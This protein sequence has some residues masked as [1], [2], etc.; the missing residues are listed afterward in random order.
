MEEGAAES[1][2]RG[3]GI[4]RREREPAKALVAFCILISVVG[5]CVYKCV[6]ILGSCALRSFVSYVKKQK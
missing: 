2:G 6:K 4:R 1:Q 3:Q 5:T